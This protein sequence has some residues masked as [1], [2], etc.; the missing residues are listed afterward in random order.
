M[1]KTICYVIIDK[2]LSRC[3]PRLI[4]NRRLL[5]AMKYASA[6]Y[7][8]PRYITRATTVRNITGITVY[9]FS[10]LPHKVQRL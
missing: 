8:Y 4:N 2:S 1:F 10:A 7:T 9:Q 6:E 5:S 3:S